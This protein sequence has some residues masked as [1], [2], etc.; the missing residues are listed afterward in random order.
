M[1]RQ[2]NR[3]PEDKISRRFFIDLINAYPPAS[4][5]QNDSRIYLQARF[6]EISNREDFFNCAINASEKISKSRSQN[7]FINYE[8]FTSGSTGNPKQ[9]LRP[10]ISWHLEFKRLRD[11]LDNSIRFNHPL[12]PWPNQI[13]YYSRYGKS[14]FSYTDTDV[15]PLHV[16]KFVYNNVEVLFQK[17]EALKEPF[18]LSGSPSSIVDLIDLGIDH[19]TPAMILISGERCP[20]P[21]LR[22]IKGL[23]ASITNLIVAREFGLIG[24]QCRTTK[25]YHF[26]SN[27]L[28][29][30]RNQDGKLTVQDPANYLNPKPIVTDDDIGF[31]EE[32]VCECG[33][34][35]LST[36]QFEGRPYDKGYPAL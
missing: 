14:S 33:F 25:L 9:C 26:F 19:F 28:A 4:N 2:S 5:Y 24:F 17:I 11:L 8:E 1:T 35:G 21:I 30:S 27:C 23:S 15:P 36:S 13:F 34:E 32:H 18:I 20:E 10:S 31:L 12:S 29:I 16:E 7:V 3:I 22:K 6:Y